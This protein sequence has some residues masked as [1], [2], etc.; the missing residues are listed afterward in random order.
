[1]SAPAAAVIVGLIGTVLGE[2]RE[3]A[4]PVRI[5]AWDGSEA[6]S[7]DP[8]APTLVIRARRA[9]RRIAW[10]PDELGVARAY[11]TGDLDVEGDLEDGFRRI[12]ELAR[13]NPVRLDVRDRWEVLR[14]AARLGAIGLPPARPATEAT[15]ATRRG[16]FGAGRF[17]MGV[18]EQLHSRDRDRAVIAHHYDLSNDFYQLVL[19]ETMAYSCAYFPEHRSGF[20]EGEPGISLADAQRAKLDLICG[21]LELDEGSTLLDIGCGWGSLSIHAARDYGARVTGITL[22]AEQRDFVRKR[23]ADAGL[24]HL[25]EVRLQDYRDLPA[26]GTYDAVCS[27]EMGEHVGEAQYPEFLARCSGSLRAGGRLLIQ[28]M[29]RRGSGRGDVKATRP[30][31]GPFIEAFIAADMH[32][33]PLGETVTEIEAAGFEVRHVQAMREHYARTG[34]AWMRNLDAHWDD[35]VALVGEETARVW[36]LY[37]VGGSLAFDEGRMGV[38]QVLAHAPGGA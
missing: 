6:G 18:R 16:W 38:D 31:G 17:G 24:Q 35:A 32:M 25:V 21:K 23:V 20:P 26:T 34:R 14:T 10:R 4:L 28:Q 1:M 8:A 33:R 13:A 36:R 12:W 2:D 15:P 5:R 37:L 9:L 19:D 7:S 11:V 29:S 27:V 22:S 30:G 3:D